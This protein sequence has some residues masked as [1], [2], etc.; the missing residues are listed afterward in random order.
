[1]SND[2]KYTN[3]ELE[4][5]E[6]VCIEYAVFSLI[7]EYGKV[8]GDFIQWLSDKNVPYKYITRYELTPYIVRY[9]RT[10]TPS[11]VPN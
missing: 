10:L 2:I 4:I 5:I 8:E 9:V 7:E 1:M 6:E 3:R 11:P